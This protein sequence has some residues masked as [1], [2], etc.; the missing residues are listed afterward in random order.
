MHSIL[1]PLSR[2]SLRSH[3]LCCGVTLVLGAFPAQA[4]LTVFT[5]DSTVQKDGP[6]DNPVNCTL[7]DAMAAANADMAVDGCQHANVGTGGP[8][9]IVLAGGGPYELSFADAPGSAG[10]NGLPRVT[11]ED[12]TIVGQP[13][14]ITRALGCPDPVADDF[15]M[16]EVAASAKLTLDNLVLE[17]GCAPSGGVAWNAGKL[18][19]RDSQLS[20]GFAFGGDGGG[21]KSVSGTLRVIRSTVSGNEATSSG[22]GLHNSGKLI[23]TRSTFAG[24]GAEYGGGLATAGGTA[25][26]RNST[27]SGN[28]AALGAAVENGGGTDFRFVNATIASN[29]AELDGDGVSN[30]S[31]SLTFQNSILMDGCLF[32]SASPVATDAGHNIELGHSCGL[33]AASSMVGTDPLI[34][35]LE[36]NGGSTPTHVLLPGSPALDAG[37]NAVCAGPDVL[38]VD[39]RGSQRPD[40][41]AASG[42][43][44]DIGAVETID[45]DGNGLDD[46]SELAM[47]PEDD[48]DAN[49]VLDRC[50]NLSPQANA[51]GDQSVE[52]ASVHGTQVMLDG[53]NSSDPDGDE[54]SFHWTGS[55]G[56]AEGPTPSVMVALGAHEMLLEVADPL[57]FTGTDTAMVTVG[58]TLAPAVEAMLE[59]QGSKHLVSFSCTDVCDSEPAASATLDGEE[60]ADGQLVQLS[61]AGARMLSVVCEDAAGNLASAEASAPE[62]DPGPGARLRWHM[63]WYSKRAAYRFGH[64][65][66]SFGHHHEGRGHHHEGRGHHHHD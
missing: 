57:G 58:D 22:G 66:K 16:F 45:C 53:T 12:V 43:I 54:L 35:L 3:L 40:G 64:H 4:D 44:C 6:G 65:Q 47:S 52:C 50:E 25:E 17:G 51:G 13:S 49:G 11:A 9:E 7:G 29:R 14:R 61:S 32:A 26:L 18:V 5:V 38:G 1:S 23:V 62:T 36:E 2:G 24:N 48:A 55:F 27:V 33:T 37:D 30:Q 19:L 10:A 20:G 60:V 39:Q 63:K 21:I 59:A 15:R 28:Q 31:G 34:G 41:D 46:G 8:F 56:A 42:G